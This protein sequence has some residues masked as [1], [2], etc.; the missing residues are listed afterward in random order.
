MQSGSRWC[1]LTVLWGIC[2]TAYIETLICLTAYSETIF[3]S[4]TFKLF[5]FGKYVSVHIFNMYFIMSPPQEVCP[6]AVKLEAED[7]RHTLPINCFCLYDCICTNMWFS[8][9]FK[10]VFVCFI[11]YFFKNK[12][13]KNSGNRKKK[14]VWFVW[15]IVAESTLCWALW[16]GVVIMLIY[17]SQ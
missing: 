14:M 2:T 5:Y 6:V 17:N 15:A 13:K 4:L 11:S 9:L 1:H 3:H 10:F 8:L 7:F 16:C 12:C